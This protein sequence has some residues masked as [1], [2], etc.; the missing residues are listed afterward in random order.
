MGKST[1][2]AL[3]V[4]WGSCLSLEFPLSSCPIL[5]YWR[6]ILTKS[7]WDAL[8]PGLGG[9]SIPRYSRI[10]VFRASSCRPMNISPCSR[11]AV[12]SLRQ[13]LKI[14]APTE[15][16]KH[17]ATE[18]CMASSFCLCCLC[19]GQWN[20]WHSR[21]VFIYTGTGHASPERIAHLHPQWNYTHKVVIP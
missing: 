6:Y 19:V 14:T 17:C 12:D 4:G 16:R 5:L 1:V 15:R 13:E 8:P 21:H 11:W 3:L 7:W 18:F 2:E 20:E 10:M 9:S